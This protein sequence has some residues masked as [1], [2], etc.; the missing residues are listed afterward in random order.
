MN[1]TTLLPPLRDTNNS[2]A[3]IYRKQRT[4]GYLVECQVPWESTDIL[5]PDT[6]GEELLVSGCKIPVD[7]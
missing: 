5:H 2:R 3:I 1:I 6:I 7:S 4:I